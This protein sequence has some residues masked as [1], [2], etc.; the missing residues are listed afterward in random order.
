MRKSEISGNPSLAICMDTC[1]HGLIIRLKLKLL[2]LRYLNSYQAMEYIFRQVNVFS[3]DRYS[4]N[5]VA[6]VVVPE[7]EVNSIDSEKM[8]K[9]ARWTNLSETT[10]LLPPVHPLADYM[11]R[12]FTPTRELPFAGHPTL[13]SCYVWLEMG[14]TPKNS[15][16]IIQECSKGL[17]KLRQ[18]NTIH[19]MLYFEAP[20]LDK[21]GDIEIN[22]LTKVANALSIS[23]SDIVYHSWCCN[24]PNWRGVFLESSDAVLAISPNFMVIDENDMDIGVIGPHINTASHTEKCHDGHYDYEVRAF[25]PTHDGGE[26]PVTGSLNAAMAQWLVGNGIASPTGYIVRQGTILGRNGRVS[27]SSDDNGQVWVGG[28]CNICITGQVIL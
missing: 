8:Q 5:P 9:F 4:G 20:S 1:M 26:D 6:V 13:G 23:I 7:S 27:I 10:F 25:C 15:E 21:S 18:S 2:S 14:V 24:G 22:E 11:L 19:N 12:I 16:Y 3:Q 17:I 28:N